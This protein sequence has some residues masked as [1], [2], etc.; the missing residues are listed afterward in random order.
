[1]HNTFSCLIFRLLDFDSEY[2]ELWDWLIDMESLVMDSHDLMMSEEQQQ[3]LYKVRATL[4]A[5]TLR[6]KI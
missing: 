2:Q 3:H 1:M 5:F 6:W 4:P